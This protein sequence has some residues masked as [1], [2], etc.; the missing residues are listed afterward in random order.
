MTVIALTFDNLGEAAAL[1]RGTWGG[2]TP[3]GADPSVTVALPRLLDELDRH[4][5]SA[6]FCVEAINCGLNPEAVRAIAGR[7][8]ELAMHGWRHE[9]WSELEPDREHE[10]LRRSRE[11]FAELG[12]TPVGFRPPGGEPAAADPEL[13]AEHG[14]AWWSPAQD[15][16]DGAIPSVPFR[17]DHVDAYLLMESFAE[18][19]A[20]RGDPRARLDPDA[21]G[22]RLRSSLAAGGSQTFV[23][24]PFL[25][26]E[27]AWWEQVQRLLGTVADLVAAGQAVGRTAGQAAGA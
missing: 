11:A 23:L 25:M 19:R 27:Q 4:A 14:I 1:E 15:A 8:H 22:A 26:L 3:L 18:L 12:L 2:S 5:L 21:A 13:L 17:W 9:R 20:L 10:L 6:T 16:G 7:G 24:H